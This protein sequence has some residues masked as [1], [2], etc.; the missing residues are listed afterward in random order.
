M[1]EEDV[2]EDNLKKA[3]CEFISMRRKVW[4]LQ[5][6]E[7]LVGDKNRNDWVKEENS[8]YCHLI[9]VTDEYGHE[10]DADAVRKESQWFNVLSNN[11]VEIDSVLSPA[12]WF[13]YAPDHKI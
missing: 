9:R 2:Q 8:S 6:N 4:Y 11:L 1:G 12:E 7:V 13:F 3:N 10:Y 5:K